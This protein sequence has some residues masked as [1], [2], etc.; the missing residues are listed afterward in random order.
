[1]G[2]YSCILVATLMFITRGNG[3]KE[4]R[5]LGL[6]AMT[7]KAYSGGWSC[8]VPVQMA[9]AEINARDDLLQG[10]ALTYDYVNHEVMF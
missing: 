2:R 10:Y 9:I 7:G 4:L 6:H 5:L 8:L 1:M 3:R